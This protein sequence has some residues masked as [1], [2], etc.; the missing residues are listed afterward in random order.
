MPKKRP[1]KK[2]DPDLQKAYANWD[3]LNSP[4]ARLIRVVAEMMEPAARFRKHHIKNTIVF[5][6]SARTLPVKKARAN[7]KNAKAKVNAKKKPFWKNTG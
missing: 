1:S 7:L 2:N 3:F 4:D 5:F 6:G